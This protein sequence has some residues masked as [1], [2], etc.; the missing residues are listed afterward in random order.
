MFNI[1]KSE[2]YS[3]DAV[4]NISREQ[5]EEFIKLLQLNLDVVKPIMI[6]YKS[7]LPF[8]IA[9]KATTKKMNWNDAVAY[10]E[11]LGEGWRLPTIE[12]LHEIYN[13]E[14]DFTKDYYWSST[15]GSGDGAWGQN[16]SD[17]N[18]F[19]FFKGYSA[20]VRAVRDIVK[21]NPT[22]PFEI[23]TRS[24][25]KMMTWYE[26]V[27]YVKSLG[28]GWRLPT[29]KELNQIYESNNDFIKDNYWSGTEGVSNGAWRQ[30]MSD[31]YQGHGNKFNGNYVRAVRSI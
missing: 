8:E 19:N 18:Q 10:I 2:T 30:D 29:K 14:N 12:E 16:L 11:S 31:G 24:P 7:D 17:G 6:K 20:Y 23:A 5:V 9:D 1:R 13:S 25:E 3:W 28:D 22:L 27:E 26:A 4:N 15:E 21:Q